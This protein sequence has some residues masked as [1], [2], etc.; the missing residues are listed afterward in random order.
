MQR[1]ADPKEPYSSGYNYDFF[2]N[3]SC[4]QMISVNCYKLTHRAFWMSP[5]APQTALRSQGGQSTVMWPHPT[6]GE[7]GSGP[8]WLKPWQSFYL[9]HTSWS[10]FL[11]IADHCY[12]WSS[13]HETL[14]LKTKS[15]PSSIEGLR[16]HSVYT[17]LSCTHVPIQRLLKSIDRVLPWAACPSSN[18]LTFH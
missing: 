15:H 16:Y 14:P 11:R 6:V 7:A 8:T 18:N 1:K 12:L 9:A 2:F 17:R 3:Q 10:L 5:P 13:S 4:L